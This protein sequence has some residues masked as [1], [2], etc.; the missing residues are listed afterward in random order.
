MEFDGKLLTIIQYQELTLQ[1]YKEARV[2]NKDSLDRLFKIEWSIENEHQLNL[3]KSQIDKVVIAMDLTKKVEQLKQKKSE[4]DLDCE[5]LQSSGFNYNEMEIDLRNVLDQ[6]I[7]KANHR[8]SS[9]ESQLQTENKTLIE[10]SSKLEIIKAD[11][12]KEIE[13]TKKEHHDERYSERGKIM[14]TYKGNYSYKWKNERKTWRYA[15]HSIYFDVGDG[16]LFK[17]KEIGLFLR[18]TFQEFMNQI[19]QG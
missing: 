3:L 2:F 13:F 16:T 7:Q 19:Y 12:E 11:E 1:N 14:N 8:L 9:L 10:L 6:E 18:F 4:I 5:H 15:R 17:R